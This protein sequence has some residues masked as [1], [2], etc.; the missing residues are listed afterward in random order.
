M[1]GMKLMCIIGN[2]SSLKMKHL[3]NSNKQTIEIRFKN[4]IFHIQKNV[5][6]V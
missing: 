5:N 3:V 6:I 4:I 1:T 2:S